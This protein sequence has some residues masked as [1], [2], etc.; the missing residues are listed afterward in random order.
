MGSMNAAERDRQNRAALDRVVTEFFSGNRRLL[1]E[2]LQL[3]RQTVYNWSSVPHAHVRAI[4]RKTGLKL[5]D[6]LPFP[7]P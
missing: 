7:Y 1:A 2:F 3:K 5:K 4:A 6:V